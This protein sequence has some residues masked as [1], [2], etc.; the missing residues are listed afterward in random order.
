VK[1]FPR[2]TLETIDQTKYLYVRV[3]SEHRFI[4]IWVVVVDGRVLVRPWND[5][6]GGWYRAFQKDSRG[7]IKLGTKEVLVRARKLR[8]TK[9]IGAMD[10][11]YA[12]KYTSK[13]NLKYVKGFATMKRQATTTELT[14]L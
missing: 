7:A 10:A 1:R 5:K 8:G 11:A 4:P 2:A 12:A 14:P 3:G 9:L 13:A 6:A